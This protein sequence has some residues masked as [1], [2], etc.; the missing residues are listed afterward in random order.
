MGEIL[1]TGPVA[2]IIALIRS[3][4]LPLDAFVLC[5]QIPQHVVT[6]EQTREDLLRFALLDDEGIEALIATSTSG[7][8]FQED[9]EL[10]WE[11][12]RAQY[13]VVYLGNERELPGLTR[14]NSLDE[15]KKSE[16]PG[17]YY[18]FGTI[19]K[20]A[21]RNQI[22]LDEKGGYYAEIRIPR[23]LRYPYEAGTERVC[24]TT[25]E[26]TNKETGDVELFRF[27]GLVFGE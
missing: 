26:Y 12:D 24:V 23:L 6:D 7:R 16:R 3:Y 4:H 10:R 18:L 20:T 21:Q 22:G 2:D 8:V 14:V 17:H 27:R 5:E 9:F 13:Q 25:C 11:K 1:A 19:L 15:L